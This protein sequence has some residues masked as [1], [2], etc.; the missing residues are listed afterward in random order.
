M[1]LHPIGGWNCLTEVHVGNKTLG[2]VFV[3]TPALSLFLVT[4]CVGI[5]AR[6]VARGKGHRFR[7]QL[8]STQRAVKS[9]GDVRGR[10]VMIGVE[11]VHPA[12]PQLNAS[13]GAIISTYHDVLIQTW[14]YA[15]W[16][17]LPPSE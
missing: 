6:K 9:I 14:S 5:P 2:G 11:M 7:E 12:P 17:L 13:A 15:R 4:L 8:R 3:P 16:T 10:G 1:T